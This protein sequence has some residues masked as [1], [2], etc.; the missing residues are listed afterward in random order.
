M[1]PEPRPVAPPVGTA[2]DWP[3]SHVAEAVRQ[4]YQALA[5]AQPYTLILPLGLVA[6]LWNTVAIPLLLVWLALEGLIALWEYRLARQYLSAPPAE[7]AARRWAQRMTLPITL[8]G[9]LWGFAGWAFFQPEHMTQSLILLVFIIGIPAGSIFFS[10]WWP[11]SQRFDLGALGLTAIGLLARDPGQYWGLALALLAYIGILKVVVKQG[12]AAAMAGIALRFD[13]LGLIARL[14]EEK[15]RAE[16]ANVAKSKFLAAASHDLRQPLHAQSL[17]LAALDE[18]IAFPE[19]KALVGQVQ[20]CTE[21]LEELLQSLLDIS[22]IDAGIIE[23]RLRDFPL[24]PLVERMQAEFAPQA[25]AA[26]LSLT[27]THDELHVRSDPGLLERILRNLLSNALRYTRTGRIELACR[28]QDGR[29]AISVR[30]TGIGIAPEQHARVFEEFVQ[31]GNPERDR[32]QG[33]GLGLA[34]VQRLARLLGT[35]VTLDSALGQGARF[36]FLLPSGKPDQSATQALMPD[37]VAIDLL[38]GTVIALVEDEADVRAAMTLLLESW[39]CQVV[40]AEDAG[41]LLAALARGA[42]TPDLAIADY[43]LRLNQTG[44]EALCQIEG[45]L[46]HPLPGLIITGDTAPERLQ[47]ARDSGRALLHKPVRPARLRATLHALRVPSTGPSDARP[48]PLV[49]DY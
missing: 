25:E 41:A 39:G 32:T 9:L 5:G 16:Q 19:V 14:S 26:G 37:I 10:A 20:R 2:I 11:P 7:G 30:D 42:P 3:D 29:V 6:T 15:Q 24:A 31:V 21:A 8:D 36:S 17:F 47:E 40:A 35:E 34:I 13:N 4:M 27:C 44:A 46:G 38:A 49:P 23:P 33:L 22:K 45:H 48:R 18:R 43:R 12:H 28:A 1:P